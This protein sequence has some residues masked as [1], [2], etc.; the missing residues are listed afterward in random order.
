V[1][2]T[3]AHFEG[4]AAVHAEQVVRARAAGV[5][6]ILAVGGSPAL[7]G[8][9]R[10][11]AAAYPQTAALALGFDRDQAMGGSPESLT[12]QLAALLAAQP[13]CALGEI[14]LDF[15]HHGPQTA[16]AQ[17]ALCGAQLDLAD[18]L[19]LPVLV[20]T[21]EADDATLA[22]LDAHPPCRHDPSRRGV[23]H[24]FTGGLGFVRQLLDRGFY[25]SFSGIVTFRN[26]DALREV[27]AYV[28][29]D[30]L[31]LETD[32]PYLAPVPLR[33]RRNEPA[34]VRSVADCVATVRGI[35]VEELEA[36]T[37]ANAARLFAWPA[38]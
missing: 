24:S 26:A 25:I 34:F 17:A 23:I 30:R 32:S 36:V 33:G 13:V 29:A 21:R 35:A 14:G 20:H 1:T 8:G 5:S 6:R 7:N 2:D 11:F 9:A 10:A 4:D 19:G 22:V 27:A 18:E 12:T 28:P 3:H 37:D 16:T 15:H 31:L 38:A